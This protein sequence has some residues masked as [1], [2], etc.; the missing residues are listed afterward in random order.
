MNG[1]LL[2]LNRP[3]GGKPAPSQENG[4]L[5][6][7]AA[8]DC[9]I[10]N[11]LEAT[12]AGIFSNLAFE[13]MEN[14]S[15]LKSVVQE[16]TQ[17]DHDAESLPMPSGDLVISVAMTPP[18]TTV[19][20]GTLTPN[21]SWAQAEG[22]SPTDSLPMR[23]RMDAMATQAAGRQPFV[24]GQAP[25]PALAPVLVEAIE[26]GGTRAEKFEQHGMAMSGSLAHLPVSMAADRLP[27]RITAASPDVTAG[28]TG[29]ALR[30]ALGQRLD[31]QVTQG[32][33]R[34][35]IR[36]D[37]PKMGTLEI[38]IQHEAGALKVQFS[39]SNGEVVRQLQSISEGLRQDLSQRQTMEVQVQVADSSSSRFA[40]ADTGGGRH[41]QQQS[42]PQEPGRALFDVQAGD[43]AT[44]YLFDLDQEPWWS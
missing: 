7:M 26:Q 42:R 16:D 2:G 36:L 19:V 21:S 12:F 27:L 31:M 9:N 22:A 23:S 20:P 13:Q 28:E 30:Q 43:D 34:A 44:D 3:V 33:E 32:H 8:N 35:V 39:A 14:E 24:T 17:P 4:H 18:L 25:R 37:P 1:L 38:A 6:E 29:Q 15:P 10:P 41:G 11:C 40:H 5:E